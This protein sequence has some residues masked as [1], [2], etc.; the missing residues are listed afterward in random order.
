M[1][2]V[3]GV[4]RVP[5]QRLLDRDRVERAVKQPDAA[6]G[7]QPEPGGEQLMDHGDPASARDEGRQQLEAV[8]QDLDAGLDT[9]Q[10]ELLDHQGG[11]RT[12]V[13]GPGQSGKLTERNAFA[14]LGVVLGHRA[15]PPVAE[16]LDRW[17]A[18]DDS[19]RHEQAVDG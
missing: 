13:S 7:P 5:P 11:M 14:D 4:D 3:V 8:G 17:Q 19:V 2:G 6:A 9:Q 18:G 15:H 10:R 12:L 1:A 16:E